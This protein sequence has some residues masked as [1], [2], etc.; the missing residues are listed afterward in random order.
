MASRLRA[1]F[2]KPCRTSRS[3]GFQPM[4]TRTASV[5]CGRQ[6]QRL[7]SPRTKEQTDWSITCSHYAHWQRGWREVNS[8]CRLSVFDLDKISSVLPLRVNLEEAFRFLY[9]DDIFC[10]TSSN[11]FNTT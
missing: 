6:E 1:R 9:F 5:R 7:T 8:S 2:V 4:T 10:L 11:Q 3:W